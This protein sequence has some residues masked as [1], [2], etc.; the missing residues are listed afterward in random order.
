[1]LAARNKERRAQTRPT[2]RDIR[3]NEATA[4]HDRGPIPG[5]VTTSMPPTYLKPSDLVTQC[6]ILLRARQRVCSKRVTTRTSRWNERAIN[7]RARLKA[8]PSTAEAA[9]DT[10]ECLE[11]ADRQNNLR[12][13]QRV[14]DANSG[15]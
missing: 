14:P 12:S 15:A 13:C 5:S 9:S 8:Y 11:T 4:A 7:A 10:P 1:M 2:C 6:I 3:L